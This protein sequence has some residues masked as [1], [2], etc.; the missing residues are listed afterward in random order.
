[1]TAPGWQASMDR[2]NVRKRDRLYAWIVA[3]QER[4]EA[5]PGRDTRD[6]Q[7]ATKAWKLR[8]AEYVQLCRVAP[9]REDAT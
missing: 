7:E 1:M 9:E 4:L 8:L 2:L 5:L 6:W 3:E